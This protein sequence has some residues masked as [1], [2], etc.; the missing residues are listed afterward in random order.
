MGDG[1]K[2][3]RKC[4][5]NKPA[6]EYRRGR[7]CRA[8]E[9]AYGRAYNHSA[10][11]MARARAFYKTDKQKQK[12]H[13]WRMSEKGLAWWKACWRSEHGKAT[14]KAYR[15]SDK[16]RERLRKYRQ[17]EKGMELRRIESKA[18][19]SKDRAR[20]YRTSPK[21]RQMIVQAASR[22]RS[23]IREQKPTL[24]TQEWRGILAK[25]NGRCAYCKHEAKLTMDHVI[26]LSRGGSHTKENVVAACGPCNFRKSNKLLSEVACG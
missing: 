12:N 9:R 15:Q 1:L 8:C 24:T 7:I 23:L 16:G 25:S 17:S 3:C 11:G 4:N 10:V 21:G 14:H 5:D 13:R 22:R 2:V 26:P 18:P 20:R 19:S 6:Y